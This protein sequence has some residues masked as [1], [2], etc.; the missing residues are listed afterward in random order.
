MT[1]TID[2]LLERAEEQGTVLRAEL[3]ETCVNEGFT[4]TEIEAIVHDLEEKGIEIVADQEVDDAPAAAPA[5]ASATASFTTDSLQLFLNDAGRYPLLTAA[6]EVELAKR[7]ERGDL[8]AKNRMINS[9]L[10][11]VVSIAKRYQGTGCRSAT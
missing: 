4:E 10:R 9:N 3:E 5:A 8:E 2:R 6:E 1:T 11:L 7:I